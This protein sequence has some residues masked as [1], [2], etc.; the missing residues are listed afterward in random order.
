M[1]CL[2]YKIFLILATLLFWRSSMPMLLICTL[3]LLILKYY[4]F[5]VYDINYSQVTY[6]K[7]INISYTYNKFK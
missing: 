5:R 6:F 2:D 3:V 1:Y 4:V 7:T